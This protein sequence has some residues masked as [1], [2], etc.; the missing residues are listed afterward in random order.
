MHCALCHLAAG[1]SCLSADTNATYSTWHMQG[2]DSELA[3][4]AHAPHPGLIPTVA[5]AMRVAAQNLGV[6]VGGMPKL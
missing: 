6:S 1:V 3:Q 2:S 4:G 5:E